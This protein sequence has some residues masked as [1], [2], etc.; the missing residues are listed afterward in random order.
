MKGRIPAEIQKYSLRSI[1]EKSKGV[2]SRH[3]DTGIASP[4]IDTRRPGV[5]DH[6]YFR[7]PFFSTFHSFELEG[8][9]LVHFVFRPIVSRELFIGI[10]IPLKKIWFSFYFPY[11][12]PALPQH[13]STTPSHGGPSQSS[14]RN[15]ARFPPSKHLPPHSAPPYSQNGNKGYPKSSHLAGISHNI[16][17]CILQLFIFAS[18]SAACWRVGNRN[19][20][21]NGNGIRSAKDRWLV[22]GYRP[23]T[24][25]REGT[26]R[27]AMGT[28]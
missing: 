2:F 18:T 20:S 19:R 5:L 1:R 10:I 15:H 13:N 26:S 21:G 16:T 9:V 7:S 27:K 8:E 28:W 22:K 12:L 24:Q 23:L 3:S 6:F 25:P 14:P 11:R 17:A 4:C